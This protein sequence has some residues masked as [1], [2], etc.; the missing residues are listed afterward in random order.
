[1]PKLSQRQR[2]MKKKQRPKTNE[3]ETKTRGKKRPIPEDDWTQNIFCWVSFDPL[4]NVFSEKLICIT[5]SLIIAV[6]AGTR[7]I[8]F[9]CRDVAVD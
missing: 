5:T 2:K 3:M 1:M 8:S 7:R 6:A 9:C 4:I